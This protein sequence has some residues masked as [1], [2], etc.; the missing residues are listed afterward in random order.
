M[1][2]ALGPQT[3]G[4]YK[5]EGEGNFFTKK[6]GPLP[7]WAIIGIVIIVLYVLY[8]KFLAG[9]NSTSQPA[10]QTNP[11]NDTG[12]LPFNNLLSGLSQIQANDQSLL[13]QLSNPS[14]TPLPINP[15]QVASS[16]NPGQGPP[17]S[18]ANYY[19]QNAGTGSGTDPNTGNAVQTPT[20][21]RG[22]PA[23]VVS[24]ATITYTPASQR[25]SW[26]PSWVR[27]ALAPPTPTPITFT[28]PYVS[29][30]ALNQ[31]QMN[32]WGRGN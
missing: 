8:T 21:A 10:V 12:T 9:Q 32:P 5:E 1:P 26:L 15:S 30:P 23:P 16:N 2:P 20:S 28:T 29:G 19:A 24:K 18:P 4:E 7:M 3:G 25:P 27:G 6:V 22:N 17:A 14:T 11:S 31:G 13:S